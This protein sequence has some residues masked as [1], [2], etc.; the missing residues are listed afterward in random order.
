MESRH[1][2]FLLHLSHLQVMGFTVIL[3][4]LM[5]LPILACGTDELRSAVERETSPEVSAS[6]L[7]DLVH[8]NTAFAIGLYQ[9]L[10]DEDGNIFFSPHSITLALAMTY[11]GARGETERQ[12]ADTLHFL[13]PQ[14]SLHPAVNALDLELSSSGTDE[15]NGDFELNIV[16]ALWGQTGCSFSPQFLDQLAESYGAGVRP[17]DFVGSPEESRIAINDWTSDQTEGRI[18]ELIPPEGVNPLT[19]LALTNAIYFKARW[20]R[21]F[22]P[23]ATGDGPFHLLDGSM[24]NVPMM[25]ETDSFGYA[26]GSGFQALS[27][28]YDVH[29]FSM[30]ILL[31]DRQRF[32][33]FEQSLDAET[34]NS[35]IEDLEWT[36]V[37]LSMPKFRFESSF[38]LGDSLEAMGMP[39][40][41]DDH[42]ADFS[43]MGVTGCPGS[44]DA[45]LFIAD[46]FHRA[47]VLVNEEGTEAAAATAVIMEAESAPPQPIPVSVDRPFL[48]LIRDSQTGAVL[49]LGRVLDPRG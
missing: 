8:G 35:I 27:L 39:D 1:S 34:V 2:H 7:S 37:S 26:R 19:R 46:I 38:E 9:N 49:F 31:P 14:D 10:S 33:E 4:A 18:M 45:Q 36:E 15:G 30:V 32:T 24:V 41:F 6:D 40:A 48:F 23:A 12:M 11:T 20:L 44:G 17:M 42:S 28:P 5:A 21:P 25:R 29:R 22:S 47:F 43:G 13:L 16:N 3:L